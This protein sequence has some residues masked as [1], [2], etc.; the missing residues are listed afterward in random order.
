[1]TIPPPPTL[2]FAAMES[3]PVFR[4]LEI[5]TFALLVAAVLALLAVNLILQHHNRLLTNRIRSLSAADGPPLGSHMVIFRGESIS[6]EHLA[7]NT[8]TNGR[9]TLL[10]VFSPSCPYCKVN[11][12]VWKAA[13]TRNKGV[14]VLYVDLSGTATANCLQSSGLPPNFPLMS[15]NPEERL[16]Y[17]LRVTPTTVVLDPSG[18]VTGKWAGVMTP[19]EADDL[20]RLLGKS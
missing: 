10:L 2:S 4:G 15:L 7:I 20:E 3:R 17:D 9:K 19:S 5:A 16:L 11:M 8:A 6:H 1:M 18:A 13:L 14:N 12:P